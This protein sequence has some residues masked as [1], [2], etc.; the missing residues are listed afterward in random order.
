MSLAKR[1]RVVVGKLESGRRRRGVE[2]LDEMDEIE[3]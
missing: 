2:R 1:T 3:E